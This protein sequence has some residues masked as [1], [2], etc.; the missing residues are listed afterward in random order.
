MPTEKY[1]NEEYSQDFLKDWAL[2]KKALEQALDIRKFEIDL[3]WKRATYFWTFIA[4]TLAGFVVVQTSPTASN[5]TDMSVLLAN[6]GIVFSFGWFC[7][8]RGSKFWQQNWEC[9]VDMLED[10]VNGPLYKV[11]T[12][13]SRPSK[14]A[15]LS[16]RSLKEWFSH[17]LTGSSEISVS[18]INQLISL[19][20]TLMWLGLLCYSLP[21]LRFDASIDWR[22]VG[23]I[24]LTMVTCTWFFTRGKTSKGNYSASS[25][26]RS[27][28]LAP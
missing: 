4:A 18:K 17:S 27:A 5:K 1:S 3:Y 23:F 13:R 19:Y 8:N 16:F 28:D 9:H 21:P 26:K 22:Y 10:K 12:R 2:H 25:T 14:S 7:V 20:V 24:A 6:L 15:G 11:V